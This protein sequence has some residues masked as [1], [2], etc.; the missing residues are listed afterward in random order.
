MADG[1][2]II[3]RMHVWLTR[4]KRCRGFGLQSPNDYSFVRDV[5]NEHRPYYA[6]LR[7]RNKYPS[8]D[9]CRRKK[10]ELYLRIANYRQPQKMIDM[11]ADAG[12][13]HDVTTAACD[14]HDDTTAAFHDYILAGCAQCKVVS[15]ND[16]RQWDTSADMIRCDIDGV[17]TLVANDQLSQG[18]ILLVEPSHRYSL[19]SSAWKRLVNAIPHGVCF[20]LYYCGIIIFDKKRYKQNYIINF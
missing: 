10:Y 6:Y 16:N 4:W 18:T 19:K 8:L 3:S 17:Y 5:I 13:T 2:F 20:D 12:D 1:S 14:K 11:L 9:A 15:R 7:M